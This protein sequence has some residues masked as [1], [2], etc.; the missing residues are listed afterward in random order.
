MTDQFD[1]VD[2]GR[3]YSCCREQAHPMR[4]DTWWYVSVSGDRTRYA[5]FQAAASDTRASVQSRIL[6]R[7]A[8]LIEYR[9][10]VVPYRRFGA[11][12]P[13]PAKPKD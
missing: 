13:A 11:A 3:T 10:N 9:A 7:Y 8:A 5:F 4:E 2:A 12:K 1:F 6:Q